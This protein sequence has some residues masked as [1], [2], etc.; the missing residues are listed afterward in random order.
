[1]TDRSPK[2]LGIILIFLFFNQPNLNHTNPEP[3]LTTSTLHRTTYPIPPSTQTQ[4]QSIGSPAP[5]F[6]ATT[7]PNPSQ[8][9]C[10]HPDIHTFLPRILGSAPVIMH[11]QGSNTP[12]RADPGNLGILKKRK[13]DISYS[14]TDACVHTHMLE[15]R[16]DDY[17]GTDRKNMW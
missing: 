7:F 10:T 6:H 9:P 8:T 15:Y 17:R 13:S 2:L 1:V 3:H 14:R 4:D 16:R 11:L 5:N 12:D